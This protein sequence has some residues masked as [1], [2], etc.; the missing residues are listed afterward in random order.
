MGIKLHY[1]KMYKIR[2]LSWIMIVLELIYPL[3][4]RKFVEIHV[5]LPF[6]YIAANRLLVHFFGV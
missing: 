3:I 2:L 4:K 1:G 6:I 5:A